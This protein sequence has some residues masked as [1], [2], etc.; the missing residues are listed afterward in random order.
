MFGKPKTQIVAKSS[1]KRSAA[2]AGIPEIE[3]STKKQ[4]T[5]GFETKV[6]KKDEK[7]QEEESKDDQKAPITGDDPLVSLATFKAA[8]GDWQK[9]L[10]SHLD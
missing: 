7:H 4:K 1:K 3:H 5:D 8:L 9:P 10:Q 6:I 2:A